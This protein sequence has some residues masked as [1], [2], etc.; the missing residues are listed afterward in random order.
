MITARFARA[1]RLGRRRHDRRS[2][3]SLVE[4]ALIFPIFVT[5]VM[6]LIEFAFV[7]N[8][9]LSVNYAARDAALAAAE[10]GDALGADCVILKAVDDA[11]GSPTSDDRIV[12]VEIFQADAQGGQLGTPTTYT[13]GG[14]TNCNLSGVSFTLDYTLGTNGY[15]EGPV[16][17]DGRRCNFL[18]GCDTDRDTD[19]V[20]DSDHLTVDNIGVRITYTHQW[21]TPIRNFI[22]GGSGGLTFD[23]SSIMRMEPVL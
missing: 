4:F 23:R 21:V 6:G 9:M 8:A 19:N 2:G 7:F 12:S 17:I 18:A 22:G 11:I 14:T 13:R 20:V 10:A 5:L 16:L 3:Q 1:R 15:R